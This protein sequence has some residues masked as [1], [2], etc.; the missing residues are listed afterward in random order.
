MSKTKHTP[1]PWHVREADGDPEVEDRI[2]AEGDG[3]FATPERHVAVIRCGLRESAANARLIAAAPELLEACRRARRVF[4]ECAED[5]AGT[6]SER[7]FK[8]LYYLMNAAI[9]KAIGDRPDT[10][11]AQSAVLVANKEESSTAKQEGE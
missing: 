4:A 10:T 3:T 2:W 1:G 8:H 6:Q 9:A 5:T 11:D 7:D